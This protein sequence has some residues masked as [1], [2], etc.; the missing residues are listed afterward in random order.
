MIYAALPSREL[1]R[2]VLSR[3]YSKLKCDI[4]GRSFLVDKNMYYE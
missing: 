2:D 4:H 3:Q 1:A